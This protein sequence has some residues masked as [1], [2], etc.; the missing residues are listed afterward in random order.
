ML[1][2]GRMTGSLLRMTKYVE[3]SPI[4]IFD[5]DKFTDYKT[6]VLERVSLKEDNISS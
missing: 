3:N 2:K 5:K 6:N 4:T 1:K